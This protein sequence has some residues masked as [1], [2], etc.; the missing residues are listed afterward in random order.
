MPRLPQ[1]NQNAETWTSTN[2]AL[3][4]VSSNKLK[5]FK[6]YILNLS[7]ETTDISLLIYNFDRKYRHWQDNHY[8]I[9]PTNNRLYISL[10]KVQ[11]TYYKKYTYKLCVNMG[12][13]RGC[14]FG[15]PSTET[16]LGTYEYGKC[17]LGTYE[18]GN[19]FVMNIQNTYENMGH[20]RGC[21][22]GHPWTETG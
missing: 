20:L 12:H 3:L 5:H 22:F 18:L 1:N 11:N 14:W 9:K 2:T 7:H 19:T 8:L 17:E 6:S 15:H 10:M 16:E 4:V 21:W 13:L